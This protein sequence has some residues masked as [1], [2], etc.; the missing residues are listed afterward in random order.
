VRTSQDGRCAR[1]SSGFQTQAAGKVLER[2]LNVGFPPLISVTH[3]AMHGAGAGAE[4]S[5]FCIFQAF[6]L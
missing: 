4:I 1:W 6:R 3:M 5:V 2:G